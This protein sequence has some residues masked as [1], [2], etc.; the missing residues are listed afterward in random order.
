[1]SSVLVR[2]ATLED[3]SAIA[4]LHASRISEGFLVTLG[5]AFL[6]RLYRRIAFSRRAF[7]LVADDAGAV[8]GFIA[9]AENTRALYVEF[10]LHD[11][12]AA[13]IAASRGIARA[14]H[15]VLETL[16]YGLRA[17][18]D[19]GGGAAAEILATG[20]AADHSGRGIGTRLVR[21]AVEELARRGVAS[22][23]VVTAVGNEAAVHAYERGGFRSQ[24]RDEVHRGVDQELL[25][26]P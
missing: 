5:P 1:M 3:V 22:A 23:R 17:G 16:R 25:V 24:G 20:V 26:W 14:P 7:L 4:A 13:A 8:C 9:V 2:F 6:R 18:N 15:S 10:L 19:D 11:G 12:I 21:A